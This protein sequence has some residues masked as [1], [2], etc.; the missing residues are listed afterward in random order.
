[1]ALLQKPRLLTGVLKANKLLYQEQEVYCTAVENENLE[2]FWE[3]PPFLS[4]YRHKSGNY[5]TSP[6]PAARPASGSGCL[7]TAGRCLVAS[8][9]FCKRRFLRRS[10]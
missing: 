1:M 7:I 6:I 9:S 5:K 8:A 4:P 10:S 3:V 2:G